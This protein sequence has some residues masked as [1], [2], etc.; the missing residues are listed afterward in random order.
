[1]KPVSTINNKIN[2]IE[3][4]LVGFS[5]PQP[6]PIVYQTKPQVKQIIP[7]NFFGYQNNIPSQPIPINPQNIHLRQVPTNLKF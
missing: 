6:L 2:Q 1:M 5:T 7:Q 4:S 3:N